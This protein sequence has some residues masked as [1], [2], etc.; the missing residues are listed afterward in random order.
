M[1]SVVSYD[2]TVAPSNSLCT[3]VAKYYQWLMNSCV[4]Y[5]IR[6]L[7]VLPWLHWVTVTT[8][9]PSLHVLVAI[10]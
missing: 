9:Q 5:H 7:M 8:F 3:A 10:R 1:C 2:V 4:F 6:R